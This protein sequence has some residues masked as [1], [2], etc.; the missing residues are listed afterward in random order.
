MLTQAMLAALFRL[1]ERQP[2]PSK[3]GEGNASHGPMAIDAFVDVLR[4]GLPR[5]KLVLSCI[6]L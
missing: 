6:N 2:L 1:G 4:R 3:N 5:M